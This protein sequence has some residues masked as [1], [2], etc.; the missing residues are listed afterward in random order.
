MKKKSRFTEILE[1]SVL[2]SVKEIS[3]ETV[4]ILYG[5]NNDLSIIESKN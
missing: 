3:V 1:I 5:R 2:K 4:V